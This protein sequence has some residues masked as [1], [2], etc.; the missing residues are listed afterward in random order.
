MVDG[1]DRLGAFCSGTRGALGVY[2]PP[3]ARDGENKLDRDKEYT[4]EGPRSVVRTNTSHPLALTLNALHAEGRRFRLWWRDDDARIANNKLHRILTIRSTAPIALAVIPAGLD[5]TLIDLVT[6]NYNI[7]V[8]QHGWNHVNWSTN[9]ERPSE[10]P[11]TRSRGD[12]VSD[13]ASGLN[14]LKTCF[15]FTFRPVFVPP[16][17]SCPAW[18]ID[19]LTQLGFLAISRDAPLFPLAS[20]ALALELNIEIDTSDWAHNGRFIGLAELTKRLLRAFDTRRRLDA[21][22][23]PIGLLT[24]HA[25][26]NS[27]DFDQ[28]EEFVELLDAS[29]VVEWNSIDDLLETGNSFSQIR[30]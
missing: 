15:P 3:I 20:S 13:L 21:W 24:H 1:T 27:R 9:G 25:T 23:A 6:S 16:W 26:L 11:E 5:T 30:E 2:E 18:M 4:A 14:I 12:V 7:S 29:H 8:L 28:L 17:H 22:S 10:F 19:A